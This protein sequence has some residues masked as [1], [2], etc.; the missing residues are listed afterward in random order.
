MLWVR[1]SCPLPVDALQPRLTPLATADEL[2]KEG[3]KA[4]KSAEALWTQWCL[5][6]RVVLD[7]DLAEEWRRA[8]AE[9]NKDVEEKKIGAPT[10]LQ[11]LKTICLHI[12]VRCSSFSFSC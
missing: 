1:S 11:D 9:A 10:Y 4:I 8:W 5:D 7:D 12:R 6:K 2:V 3:I